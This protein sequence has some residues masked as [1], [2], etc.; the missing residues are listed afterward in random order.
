MT[1][2]ASTPTAVPA[3]ADCV[4]YIRVSTEQ[5]AG[6]ARTSLP[7]QRRALIERARTMGRVLDSS[8]VF[9]DAGISGATAEGRPAFMALLSFCEAHPRSAGDGVI[10][11]LNDSRFGRFDDPEEATHWRF[12]LKR[13][14]WVVRFA[15]GDD[16]VDG[17]GRSVMRLIGSAQASE[18]RANL[19]RTAKRATRATA[20]Q[21]RWQNRAPLGFRRLA[22]RTDGAQRILEAGQRKSEDEVT[23]L[24]PG[25]AE[26]QEIIRFAFETYA[27]GQVSLG[28][29][30]MQL[31]ERWPAR[32]WVAATLNP[33]LKNPAYVG[34]V[35]WCRRPHDKA[36]RKRARVRPREEWVIV[37]DA[38]PALVSRE[39][40]AEVQRRLAMNKKETRA[41]AGGYPLSGM[42]TCATCGLPFTGG[43]GRVGPEHDR[44]R[45]RAYRDSSVYKIPNPCKGLISTLNKRWV[46]PAVVRAIAGVVSDER[47]QRIIVEELDRALEAMFDTTA[48]RRAQLTKERKDLLARRARLVDAVAKETFSAS[49][50]ASAMTELRA[51]I[52]S[53]E[54]ELERLQFSQRQASAVSDLRDRLVQMAADFEGTALRA[55]GTA[56]RE[57]VRPWLASAVYSKDTRTITLRIR[58]IP[59]VMGLPGGDSV[60]NQMSRARE[61]GKTTKGGL[62]VTRRIKVPPLIRKGDKHPRR[63]VG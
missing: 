42:I 41:T 56:L 6:D 15:E 3:G 55:G 17:I 22:T 36:D 2:L 61:S 59:D 4:G 28:K 63:R 27:A 50:A 23:R 54:S 18:Y 21:G 40:F 43:G 25:P 62:I 48:A 8:A 16:V 10:L 26:E 35:V 1:P 44:D 47:V 32:P 14:G 30:V 34:D 49:E 57:L 60:W 29:L 11:V 13:L 45:Y 52:A 33:M 7:E 58:R 24:T 19:K 20:E 46:E 39:V 53:T 9:V 51:K 12:V 31:R 5:Q 37:T 38:H